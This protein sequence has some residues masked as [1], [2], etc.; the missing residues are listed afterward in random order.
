MKNFGVSME[1]MLRTEIIDS[2]FPDRLPLLAQHITLP[3]V[4]AAELYIPFHLLFVVFQCLLNF[5]LKA[6]QRKKTTKH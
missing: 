3:L 5:R 2:I 1:H 4:K 6:I